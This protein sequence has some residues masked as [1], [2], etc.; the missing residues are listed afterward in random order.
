MPQWEGRSVIKVV[1]SMEK[2]PQKKR[3]RYDPGVLV[4]VEAATP[5]EAEQRIKDEITSSR[6]PLPPG[7]QHV[8]EDLRQLKPQRGRSLA[9]WPR[10]GVRRGGAP[11]CCPVCT[12]RAIRKTGQRDEGVV[13]GWDGAVPKEWTPD[14]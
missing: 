10:E 13:I 6:F 7:D 1:T 12:A 2:G 8:V 9:D 11:E 3:S 5:E 4:V 14:R